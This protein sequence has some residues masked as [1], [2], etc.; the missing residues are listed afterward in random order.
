MSISAPDLPSK[1]GPSA[2]WTQDM[3][4]VC[5]QKRFQQIYK[6][7]HLK[8]KTNQFFIA[9]NFSLFSFVK[10]FLAKRVYNADFS[11]SQ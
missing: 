6:E 7:N 5:D 4:E 11:L 9:S 10:S 3:P 1:K 2:N 8:S